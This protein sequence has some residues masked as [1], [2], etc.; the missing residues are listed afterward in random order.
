MDQR[1]TTLL[2]LDGWEVIGVEEAATRRFCR[3]MPR[4]RRHA[5]RV[6]IQRWVYLISVSQAIPEMG[7]S[8]TQRIL[9]DG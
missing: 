6:A 7:I 5:R 3:G 4:A 2:T 8:G 1:I 9:G